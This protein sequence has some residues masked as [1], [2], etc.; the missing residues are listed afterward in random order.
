M[1]IMSYFFNDAL[2]I[3][4][5]K[6]TLCCEVLKNNLKTGRY[7]SEQALQAFTIADPCLTSTKSH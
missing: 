6:N 7:T 5:L 1:A 3:T 4:E 2:R